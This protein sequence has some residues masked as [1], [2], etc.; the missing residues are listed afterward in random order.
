MKKIVEENCGEK[1]PFPTTPLGA[2]LYYESIGWSVIP[3]RA[4][5]MPLEPGATDRDVGKVPLV[6]WTEF[7]KR[8]ATPDEI[9]DWFLR[10][11]NA[12]VGIV[13]GAISNLAVID[14]DTE[15]AE[16]AFRSLH[17]EYVQAHGSGSLGTLAVSTSRGRHLYFHCDPDHALR[18]CA[19]L[20]PGCDL[21]A[22]GGYIVAPPSRH[23]SGAVYV[24]D[25]PFEIARIKT[26]LPPA[27]KL[28]SQREQRGVTRVDHILRTECGA[29]IPKGCRNETL[30]RMA[31]SMRSR[32]ICEAAILAALHTE[33]RTCCEPP[34]DDREVDLLANHAFRQPHRDDFQVLN[35]T[36]I[37]EI[38]WRGLSE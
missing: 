24:W 30:Y 18:S 26:I 28:Y 25:Q 31:R 21:R 20:L 37:D 33:N 9:R 5:G 16:E 29:A 19:A 11:P 10:W 13:T 6:K 12:N 22:E 38:V 34:L 35:A 23:S 15:E 2:A 3:V 14:F 17:S 8:R 4:P 36:A 32:G 27:L 7:Q 1:P